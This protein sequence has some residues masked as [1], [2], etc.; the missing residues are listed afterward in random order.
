M[1]PVIRPM[2]AALAPL[3]CLALF[4]PGAARA[5]ERLRTP[6]AASE[7]IH[8]EGTAVLLAG[9]IRVVDGDTFVVGAERFRLRRLNAPERGQPNA[10]RATRRLDALLHAGPVTVVR[11]GQDVYGRTVVDVYVD[12]RDVAAILRAEGYDTR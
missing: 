1:K 11:H 6:S 7:A 5:G 12:G 9:R 10:W 3:A 4:V 8:A 2:A